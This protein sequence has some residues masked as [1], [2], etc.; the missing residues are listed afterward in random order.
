MSRV[1]EEGSYG[2]TGEQPGTMTRQW[3]ERRE[4]R[5][6]T[7]VVDGKLETFTCGRWCFLQAIPNFSLPIHFKNW[8]F[9]LTNNSHPNSAASKLPEGTREIKETKYI[10][11]KPWATAT[12]QTSFRHPIKPSRKFK[13]NNSPHESNWFSILIPASGGFLVA[14]EL[15]MGFCDFVSIVSI[16]RDIFL[17]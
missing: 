2:R 13:K 8:S 9:Y 4:T 15:A 7:V 6:W 11:G 14:L 5:G 3:R 1:R 10:F 16:F 17:R 12:I